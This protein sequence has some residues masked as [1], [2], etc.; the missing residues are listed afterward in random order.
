MHDEASALNVAKKTDAETG[1][2]VRAL[3]ESGEIGDD[4]RA[5][6]LGTVS[7]GAAIRIDYT[8]V[9]FQRRE[10]I[11]CD[12]GTRSRNDGNQRG[13]A[14]VRETDQADVGEKLE[15]EA[16]MPLFTGE[17]IFVFSSGLLPGPAKIFVPASPPTPLR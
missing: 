4:E 12:F 11:I 3:D 8:K 13:F 14:C 2:Q 1:T 17:S 5:A 7:A 16:E 15:F 10:R 6:E 9:G